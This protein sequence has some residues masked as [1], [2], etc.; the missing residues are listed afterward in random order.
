[1]LE[2]LR[3]VSDMSASVLSDCEHLSQV[4]FGLGVTLETVLVS[5]LFLADLTEP[6]QPLKS[7]G[8]HL[9]G[10]VLGR[11]DFCARHIG[12][13]D[14]WIVIRWSKTMAVVVEDGVDFSA[15]HSCAL[16]ITNRTN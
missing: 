8:L 11:S 10:Y 9:V 1:V 12:M 16:K 15:N 14:E 5:T 4:S 2:L 6:A 13:I 3:V 7:L